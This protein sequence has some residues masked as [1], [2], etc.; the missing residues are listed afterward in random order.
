MKETFSQIHD[1]LLAFTNHVN[2]NYVA[3]IDETKDFQFEPKR[4]LYTVL[5]K[6]NNG[7]SSCGLFLTD[8]HNFE[9][10]LDGLFLILRTL[11]SDCLITHYVIRK[12]YINDE[13]IVKNILP[14]YSEHLK[15]GLDNLRKYGKKFW[16][17]SDAQINKHVKS[18]IANYSDYINKDGTLIHKP[19]RTTMGQKAEYL[20]T[21]VRDEEVKLLIIKAHSLYMLFSKYEH[22]GIL[23][24]SLM[25]RQFDEKKKITIAREIVESVIIIGHTIGLTIKIWQQFDIESDSVVN[26]YIN[27][28]GLLREKLLRI[29][30]ENV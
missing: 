16:N 25:Q 23:S 19:E 9:R 17:Y 6:V 3:L 21:N 5:Y 24:L 13:G 11:I 27:K 20:V 22:L 7:L 14:L 30:L 29:E 18:F 10:H 4:F 12:N 2:Q 15:F 8:T 1:D 26:S 28:F